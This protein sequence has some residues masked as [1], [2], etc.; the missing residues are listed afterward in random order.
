MDRSP[1]L[2][3]LS[4]LLSAAGCAGSS[5]DF[6]S[7]APR[8]IEHRSDAVATPPA[9]APTA[10]DPALTAAIAK[11]VAQAEAGHAVFTKAIDRAEPAIARGARAGSGSDAWADAQTAAS[12]VVAA[13]AALQD[14]AAALDALRQGRSEPSEADTVALDAAAARLDAL[15]AEE[16]RATTAL[17]ARLPG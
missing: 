15:S 13:R 1:R 10:A 8:E 12:S 11:V 17:L 2:L 14:A 5:G 3:A 6:P 7:L 9:P 4:L 16:D